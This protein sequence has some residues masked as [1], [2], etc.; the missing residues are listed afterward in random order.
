M[1]LRLSEDAA[2]FAAIVRWI[3]D[4]DAMDP[5][6]ST[7]IKSLAMLFRP[8]FG[9]IVTVGAAG[10]YTVNDVELYRLMDMS[11]WTRFK[12]LAFGK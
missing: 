8:Q 6:E 2:R 7:K 1:S 5:H 4:R 11:M 9:R 3:D 12:E 10:V